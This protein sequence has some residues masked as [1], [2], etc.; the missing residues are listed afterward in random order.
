MANASTIQDPIHRNSAGIDTDIQHY[1]RV[2]D[3]TPLDLFGQKDPRGI[4]PDELEE[5]DV[6]S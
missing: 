6:L 3:P 2:M 5:V 4:P 1:A